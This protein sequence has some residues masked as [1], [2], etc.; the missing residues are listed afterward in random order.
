MTAFSDTYENLILDYIF[1]DGTFTA[2]TTIAVGL[3]TT[4]AADDDTGNLS[5]GVEVATSIGYERQTLSDA[6]DWSALSNGTTSNETKLTYGPAT[7]DWGTVVGF[8]I[9]DSAT[10]SAGNLIMHGSLTNS[11][12]VYSG[13]T[14]EINIGSLILQLK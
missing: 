11:R 12:T 9:T 8:I 4:L 6:A 7:D 5:T 1:R 3:V 13:D 2:P 10:H 14:F